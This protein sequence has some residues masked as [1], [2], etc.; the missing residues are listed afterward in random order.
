MKKILALSVALGLGIALTG[1]G[2]TAT[3]KPAT[4]SVSTGSTPMPTKHEDTG[5]APE[6][7]KEETKKEAPKE[8]K[9][10]ETKKEETK[11]EK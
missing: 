10:E 11:K 7:K 4:H 1:C 2:G 8:T 3:T 6:T 9:K 5:K